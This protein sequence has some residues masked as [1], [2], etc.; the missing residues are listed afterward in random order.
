V[1]GGPGDL[2]VTWSLGDH[3]DTVALGIG[4]SPWRTWANKTLWQ[5]GEWKATVADSNGQV[6]KEISFQVQ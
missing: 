6:L 3:T 2:K 1:T 5:A 4:G